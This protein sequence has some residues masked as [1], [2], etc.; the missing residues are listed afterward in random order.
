[1]DSGYCS[2]QNLEYLEEQ[3]IDAYV[4]TERQKH[5]KQRGPC[6]R[7]RLPKGAT[8][9]ERM[10]RKL[11]TKAGAAIYAAR[12][13]IVEPVFGQIKQARESEGRGKARIQN[14]VNS[15]YNLY[16]LRRAGS[17]SKQIPRPISWSAP[18]PSQ[19]SGNPGWIFQREGLNGTWPPRQRRTRSHRN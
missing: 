9:V 18:P 17:S 1:M 10:K 2:E 7:E 14:A 5:G 11:Q 6:T 12:K 13:S 8:R 15:D 19:A 4:A 16:R 3:K